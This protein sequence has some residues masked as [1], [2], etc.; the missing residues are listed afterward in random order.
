MPEAREKQQRRYL[1]LLEEWAYC[2]SDEAF[3]GLWEGLYPYLQQACADFFAAKEDREHHAAE[4]FT[5]K[6]LPNLGAYDPNRDTKFTSWVWR[7]ARNYCKD[8]LKRRSQS[9][10]SLPEEMLG[11]PTSDFLNDDELACVVSYTVFPLNRECLQEI[12]NIFIQAQ[13]IPTEEATILTARTLDE[14]HPGWR[15]NGEEA[16][17]VAFLFALIRLAKMDDKAKLQL[18]NHLGAI[19]VSSPA[20]LLR[21]YLPDDYLAM[22][23]LLFGGGLLKLPL[24]SEILPKRRRRRR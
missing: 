20:G 18:Q 23:I 15:K 13:G 19:P 12:A 1:E 11:S 9:D 14:Y 16:D 3:V 8:V 17:I 6:I 21:N 24:A 10:V 22:L 5:D 2:G 4:I 7:L